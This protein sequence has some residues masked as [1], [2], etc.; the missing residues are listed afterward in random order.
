MRDNLKKSAEDDYKRSWTAE[1]LAKFANILRNSNNG[2]S[3]ALY[4]ETI[5]NLI[6]YLG[7]NQGGLFILNDDR[8]YCCHE[9]Q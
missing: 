6:K 7:A 5:S 3:T 2:D 9:K 1:G 8:L 4:D